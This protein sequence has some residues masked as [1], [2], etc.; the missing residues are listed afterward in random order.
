[1]FDSIAALPIPVLGLIASLADPYG[2]RLG[3]LVAGTLVVHDVRER[4]HA[5]L[6]EARHDR[7]APR[8]ALARELA[9]RLR[10]PLGHAPDGSPVYLRDIWPS[11]KEI[12][13]A[14]A[15]VSI[16][17]NTKKIPPIEA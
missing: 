3:D 1:M 15:A 2:R 4:E 17:R 13:D 9:H 10:D 12:G 5:A 14:I 6:R 16:L 7:Q 8:R 11:S